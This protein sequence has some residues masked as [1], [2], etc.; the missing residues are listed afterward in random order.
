MAGNFAKNVVI[1]VKMAKKLSENVVIK[2]P[3][4][5]G[6][7]KYLYG[8]SKFLGVEPDPCALRGNNGP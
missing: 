8:G 7:V 5:S 6:P 1:K 2:L 3:K 4:N